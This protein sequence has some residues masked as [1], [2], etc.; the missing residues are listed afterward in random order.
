MAHLLHCLKKLA[1]VFLI[2]V[3]A[4]WVTPANAEEQP[5][6]PLIHIQN[7]HLSLFP[8]FLT[9]KN[10]PQEELPEKIKHAEPLFIDLIRDLG[11]RQGEE[12][13]N[14]GIGLTDESIR[15]NYTFLIEYE[16]API[17]RLG[18]EL[19]LPFTFYSLN[20]NTDIG[21]N[22][23]LN[24]LN[25]FKAAIQY[26]FL[27]EPTWQTSLAL[28]YIHE[29]K[30]H[31]FANWS[32]GQFFKGNLYNPFF[33][34]A[35]AWS[36]EWHSL[37]YTGPKFSQLSSGN[38]LSPEYEINTSVHYLLPESRNFIGVEINQNFSQQGWNMV[39]RPQM[40]LNINEQ[41]LLGLAVGIPITRSEERLSTFIRLIYEPPHLI[42][43]N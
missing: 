11:A 19:E 40:R 1:G 12:E 38:W 33:V 31:P 13:W 18:L 14:I 6:K 34:A 25:A 17:D 20:Q 10:R 24:Q 15:D 32:S 41:L 30:F 22:L 39:I 8:A 43:V 28:G 7:K 9:P 36:Q 3:G 29:L 23:A 27:V 21:S 5:E 42:H 37:I 16:W 4:E 35:K 2:T 26:T